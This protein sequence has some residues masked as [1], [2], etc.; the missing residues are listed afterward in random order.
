MLLLDYIESSKA[1]SKAA[2]DQEFNQ[3]DYEL[4]HSTLTSTEIR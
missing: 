4:E 3:T 2:T 1:A